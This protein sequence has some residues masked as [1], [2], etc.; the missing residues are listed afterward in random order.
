MKSLDRTFS[1]LFGSDVYKLLSP[2]IPQQMM[3]KSVSNFSSWPDEVLQQLMTSL[4]MVI[5]FPPM[6]FQFLMWLTYHMGMRATHLM[7]PR[8]KVAVIP[9]HARHTPVLSISIL[10]RLMC[11]PNAIARLIS[12]LQKHLVLVGS[13]H[14]KELRGLRSI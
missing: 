11:E 14:I 6:R 13:A 9:S 3:P 2:Q 12:A 1:S 5:S 7:A 10:R 4:Y 8:G